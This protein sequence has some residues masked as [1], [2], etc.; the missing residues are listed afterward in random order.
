[1]GH[2]CYSEDK[3]GLSVNNCDEGFDYDENDWN[4]DG[5]VEE[6]NANDNMMK[7]IEGDW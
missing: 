1:M 2:G 5:E 7:L 6:A 4:T 3:F